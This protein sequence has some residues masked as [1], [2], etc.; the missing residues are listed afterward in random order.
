VTLPHSKAIQKAATLLRNARQAVA[1]TGAGHSTPSGIPDFRS[2]DSGVW[3][4]VDPAEVASIYNFVHKPEAFYNWI[5][6]MAK[7]MRE[8]KPN[9]AHV[10]LAQMEAAGYLSA[11]VTQNIDMLHTRAGSREVHELHGNMQEATC[12]QCYEVYEA[13]PYI[14][15]VIENGGVPHCPACDGVLKPNVILFGEQLPAHALLAAERAARSSDVMLVAG[16]SLVVTPAADLPQLALSNGARLI[17]VNYEETYVDQRADVVIHD[18]VAEIL[19][20]IAGE[21]GAA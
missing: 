9:P 2:P 3:E 18:D 20:R 14:D 16:S 15:K 4:N 7:T 11:I 10:A 6:P 17:V 21:L 5:R 13:E 8:A 1:L 12:I 19:P